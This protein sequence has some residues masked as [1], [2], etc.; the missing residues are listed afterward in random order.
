MTIKNLLIAATV[1]LLTVTSGSNATAAGVNLIGDTITMKYY[2][3][4]INGA[5]S[6]RESAAVVGSGVEFDC[7]APPFACGFDQPQGLRIDISSRRITFEFSSPS[8]DFLSFPSITGS[9]AFHGYKFSGFNAD[10]PLYLKTGL[11]VTRGLIST[12]TGRIRSEVDEVGISFHD[13]TF[14]DGD[15]VWFNLAPV[16]A[17]P[18]PAAMPLLLAGM[19]SLV[20]L[21]RGRRAPARLPAA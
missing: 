7:K 14:R 18:T 21:R 10:M 19:C 20:F 15:S 5:A 12:V 6:V 13:R 4:D 3:G 11:D 8:G 1:A 17:L 16:T 9:N 2:H